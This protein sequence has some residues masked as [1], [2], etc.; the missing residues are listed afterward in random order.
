MNVTVNKTDSYENES[1][2]INAV[3]VTEEI[4]NAIDILRNNGASIPVISEGDTLLIRTAAIYYI[5]SVD[6]RTYVYTK[7]ECHETKYRLYELEELL[8]FNFLRCSKAMIVN[9]KKIRSVRAELNARLSA[10]L[11]NGERL[12]ISRG[13]VKDLKKKL[14]VNRK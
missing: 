6:K 9:I 7:D 3:A 8:G 10:E 14:G 4:R 5:E 12:I 13:Y 11:L 1:A 2:V